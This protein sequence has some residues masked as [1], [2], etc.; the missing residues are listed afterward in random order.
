M[1]DI[2]IRRLFPLFG[3]KRMLVYYVSNTVVLKREVNWVIE[4]NTNEPIYI[5]I[6]RFLEKKIISGEYVGEFKMAS[7]REL[8]GEL[9]VN[10]NTIQRVYTELEGDDLIYTKRGIGKFVT[11]DKKIINNLR[12]DISKELIKKFI[13]DTKELGFSKEEILEACNDFYEEV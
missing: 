13:K 12:I 1:E 5:Q 6:K 10:P 9:K 8:A 4:F 2:S 11:S 7:V 3:K